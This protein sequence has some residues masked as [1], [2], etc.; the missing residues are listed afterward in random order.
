MCFELVD[1]SCDV[2]N[3]CI[4]PANFFSAEVN[5]DRRGAAMDLYAR[6]DTPFWPNQILGIRQVLTH[7]VGDDL[8]VFWHVAMCDDDDSVRVGD[9]HFGIHA[10]YARKIQDATD[11][12][13]V[14]VVNFLKL[15][16][17]LVVI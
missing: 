7:R 3:C 13:A 1:N 14:V 10:K 9:V 12:H 2:C 6:A 15:A 4:Q 8:S 5:M 16:L 11:A 17:I